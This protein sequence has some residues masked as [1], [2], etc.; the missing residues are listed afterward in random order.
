MRLSSTKFG[1]IC[2]NLDQ[3][4]KANNNDGDE[5]K[6]IPAFRALKHTAS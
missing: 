2:E 6:G 4:V 3:F 5:T 1:G